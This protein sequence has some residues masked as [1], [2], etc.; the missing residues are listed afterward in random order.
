VKRV[1]IKG[2][3]LLQFPHLAAGE[4]LLHGI[5][6]RKG[7]LSKGP[8]SSL[9]LG[10]NTGDSPDDVMQNRKEVLSALGWKPESLVSP[11]QI[12]GTRVA[13]VTQSSRGKG[14]GDSDLGFGGADGMI[15]REAGLLLMI[16]VADC[17]PVFFFDP[18]E[19]AI[20][21][22]HAGWR[23]AAN[24]IVTKA[25]EA[26]VAS[27]Q[28]KPEHTMAGIGPGIGPCCFIVGDDVREAFG[29]QSGADAF[30]RTDADS[31]FHFDLKETI[32]R[33]LLSCGL[34]EENI[35]TAEECTCCKEE[36]F[37]SHRR[38]RGTTGRMA[39][40]IGLRG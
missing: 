19:K 29:N 36:L 3:D 26:M 25:I 16:K 20:G 39:A 1:T 7:G 4:N 40:L 2:L 10:L 21:L 31:R 24:G 15:T 14:W 32:L 5:T 34:R 23:G 27:F 33:E 35:G 8:F 12:H 17:L 13:T 9:N 37:Y 30:S 28:C 38:D 11:V 22:I 18:F 6:T